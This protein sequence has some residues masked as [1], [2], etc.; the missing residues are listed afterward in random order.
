M[1]TYR[2]LF[3]LFCLVT[4][5]I[6]VAQQNYYSISGNIVDKGNN[7][8]ESGN[9]IALAAKDSSLLKGTFFIGGV[10]RLDG[11]LEEKIYVKITSIGYKDTFQFV[12]R[13]NQDSLLNLGTVILTNNNTLKEIEITATTPMFE[14]DGEKVKVNVENSALNAVGTALD[15]LKKSP[16]VMV[17][18]SDNVSVFGKGAAVIYVDGQ[19]ITSVDILKTISSTE[20]KEIEI[21]SNPSAK[22]DASGKAVINI[23]TKKNNLEGYSGNLIQIA[24]Y[25]KGL[26]TYTGLRF[27]YKR[28]KWSTFISYG[29][30]HGQDWKT[31]EY[32]RNVKNNDS[33]TTVM[34]N[35]I[36]TILNQTDFQNY[37]AGATY[38]FDS[39]SSIGIQYTGFYYQ[40]TNFADNMNEVF[41]NAV[42]LLTI[43][44]NT[45][46]KPIKIMNS[47]NIYFT[48]K[49]D[50]LQSE[51]SLAA[52]YGNYNATNSDEI[53]QQIFIGNN[54]NEQMKRNNGVNAIQIFTAQADLIKA[55]NKN[56]KLESGIKGS[57]ISNQSEINLEN[58]SP[59]VW[60][61]DPAYFN[62]FKY[63]ENILAGYSQLRYS[64]N[65]INV[66]VGGRAE[67]SDADGFSKIS[68]QQVIKRK[69]INLFPSAFFGYDLTKNI[70][71]SLTYSSRITRPTFQDLDP[72]VNFIDSL[73]SFRGNPY[74]LPSYTH[75]LEASVIY[76]QQA[77]L[78]FGYSRTNGE[79]ALVVDKLNDATDAFIATTKN[80]NFSETYSV[81]AI[82]PYNLGWWST[83][84]Y[85]GY[86]KNT[87]AFESGG[88]MV[89]NK[90][91]TFYM[92]L[93]DEFRV[94]KI[95]SMEVTFE[96]TSAGANGIFTFEPFSNL[97]AN[98]KKT[99]FKDKLTCRLTANDILSTSFKT[100][101]SNVNG[102]NVSYISKA[103]T[104]YFSV[105]L[106][107]HFG[108]LKENVD[109]EKT[110][111]KEEYN[112]IKKGK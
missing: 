9:I 32:N 28:K 112:R 10:F 104:H 86:M 75:S 17:D 92:Y 7:S 59:G 90:K 107:Y 11:L 14:R 13:Q 72:F 6:L 100:G 30:P 19:Q 24:S 3:F 111:D 110:I 99:F 23:I 31:D 38:A 97:S 2:F 67:Y 33:T 57:F 47:A 5:Q 102:Y 79:M 41:K 20:I 40:S 76:M 84:N 71:T 53:T 66:R 50:T 51:Y 44:T 29:L 70:N 95:L 62:G 37:R 106:N 60:V 64:K 108:K 83:Y 80:L 91:L 89:Q 16:T 93:H 34:K 78:V 8:I 22:Y 39:A 58:Y 105:S 43:Q 94:K 27:N 82:I 81:G 25:G 69:D 46:S 109:K 26:L 88:D 96:Y 77:S 12:G 63:G 21:I 73:S 68:G 54:S 101:F 85:F 4:T 87:F 1:L 103:N 49:I 74:L 55:F 56:W 42:P 18:N 15:I 52:Q 98:I 65:K 36:F 48:K 61:S 45:I 35:K